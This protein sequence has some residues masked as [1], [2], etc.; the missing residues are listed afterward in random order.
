MDYLEHKRV[1]IASYCRGRQL[2]HSEAILINIPAVLLPL[3]RSLA[4]GWA[5]RQL[6]VGR[7]LRSRL[8]HVPEALL[9]VVATEAG[10]SPS[11]WR[12]VETVQADLV[13]GK[14]TSST[15]T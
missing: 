8:L 13:E 5:Y 3:A 4:L 12:M 2:A 14:I 10:I 6:G 15:I 9:D 11:Q 1:S 7:W